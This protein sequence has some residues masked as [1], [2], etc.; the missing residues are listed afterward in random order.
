MAH[1]T[2]LLQE[3]I[4]GLDIHEGD[5]FVDCTINGGGHSEEVAKRFGK[6][7]KIVGIDMDANALLKAKDRLTKQNADFVLSQNNFRNIDKVLQEAGL[8]QA[9]RILYDLGLSSNQFDESGRGFSF[10]KDESLLMT[11]KANPEKDDLTAQEIVNTWD[12]ENIADILYGYGGETFSRAIAKAI[13]EARKTAP[14]L[15]T[16][17]LVEIIRTATPGFYHH[18]K[19]H[20]A[21]KTFQALR[22]TTNDEIRA[23]EQ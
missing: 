1:T 11:F 9:Y 23:L 19:I 12:E 4:D 16:S 8:K 14:I 21:T 18:R 13:V 22:I 10:Q 2:V 5:V 15:K 6:K 17:D 7:V 20:F 3:S